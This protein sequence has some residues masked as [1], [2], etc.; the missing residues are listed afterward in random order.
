MSEEPKLI[1]PWMVAVWPG[2]GHVAASA[3]YYLMAKLGMFGLAEFSPR[4]VFD[5]DH[6]EVQAGLIKTGRL[7]RSRLFVWKDPKKERDLVVFIGEAQ[8]P[9]GRYLF[10]RRLVE[11]AQFLGVERLHTFAAMATQMHP[12]HAPRVFVAATSEELR[13]E[14]LQQEVVVLETGQISGLNGVLLGVAAEMGLHGACLLGEMPHLFAQFPFPAA[15]LSVLKAFSKMA[16]IEVDL[17]ELSQQAQETGQR[18]GEILTEVEQKIKE[19]GETEEESE[20]SAQP[21]QEEP[22]VSPTDERR[23]EQLFQK[24]R[25]DRSKAYELKGEL[26]RL[27]VFDLYEDRFLDLFKHTE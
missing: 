2:M 19:Q 22:R 4:E 16:N 21:P 6:V 8:P 5:V 1:K 12:T 15:S 11:Y 14:L 17:D 26:D 23:L 18:L 10:C 27:G 20:F 24:A 25:E 13:E 9:I 7:P 3:G